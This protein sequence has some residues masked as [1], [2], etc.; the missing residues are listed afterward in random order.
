MIPAHR[1]A[2]A[3]SS[4]RNPF[5]RKKH[6]STASFFA[7]VTSAVFILWPGALFAQQTGRAGRPTVDEQV[8][9]PA[10]RPESA[11]TAQEQVTTDDLSKLASRIVTTMREAE[12]RLAEGRLDGE[13]GELQG[14]INTDLAK[15]RAALEQQ[16]SQPVPVPGDDAQQQTSEGGSSSTGG[17]GDPGRPGGPSTEGESAEGDRPGDFTDTEL[18]RR[19][20]L[21]TAV[22]GHLPEKE[23]DEMLGAFSERFL[24]AYDDLVR[25]YYEALATRKAQ[26]A[27]APSP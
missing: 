23:R 22:W 20:N 6:F 8:R 10:E 26:G 7:H 19:R 4:L 1:N 17:T 24:P 13:T 12:S 15:L 27:D 18:E 16:A 25:Q 21:A 9:T 2:S 3:D 11:R 5:P 14:Q